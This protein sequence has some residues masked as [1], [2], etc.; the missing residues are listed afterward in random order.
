MIPK[1]VLNTI[2]SDDETY[3]HLLNL[4]MVAGALIR[5]GE[6]PIPDRWDRLYHSDT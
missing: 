1:W 2:Y 4:S 3:E 6:L 5:N